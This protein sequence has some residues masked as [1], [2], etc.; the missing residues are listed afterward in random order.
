MIYDDKAYD[1]PAGDDCLTDDNIGV[2]GGFY[3]SDIA[4]YVVKYRNWI[5]AQRKQSKRR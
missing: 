5:D 2:I 3:S 1:V 4:A